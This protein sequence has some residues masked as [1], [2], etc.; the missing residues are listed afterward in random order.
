VEL[1]EDF[2]HVNHTDFEV[3]GLEG[4][5]SGE[6]EGDKRAANHREANLV[7]VETTDKQN[8]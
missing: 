6:G 3:G 8:V 5:G 4:E 2:G 1:L 7:E